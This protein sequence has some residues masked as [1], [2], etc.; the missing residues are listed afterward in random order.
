MRTI[1]AVF[2]AMSLAGGGR[3]AEVVLREQAMLEGSIVRLG[4][5]ADLSAADPG[6]VEELAAVPLLPAPTAAT[7]LYL[8]AAQ[9]RDL[10][11]ASGVDVTSLE[12]Q[13]ADSVAIRLGTAQQ[14]V[15]SP[16]GEQ[17][18]S[19]R[20]TAAGRVASAIVR[21]LHEQT[22]HEL[23]AVEVDA[24]PAITEL[25]WNAGLK[26]SVAGGK[27]PFTGRQSFQ[28]SD[29]T[30]ARTARAYAKVQR[31]EMVV[32]ATR[33]IA[34]GDFVRAP[35]VTL[36]P[37]AGVVSAQAVRSVE[38][39]VGQEAVQNIRPGAMLVETQ[40]RPPLLVQRGERV[41]VHARAAGIVVRTFAVAQQNG[42]LGDLVQVQSLEGKDRYAARVAGLRELEVFAAGSSADEIAAAA[43]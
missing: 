9:I 41:V 29:A 2:I 32:F 21:Y 26:L 11:A 43:E 40:V 15:N 31:L 6:L 17:D 39:V 20:E 18:G 14:P 27:E 33:A 38:S 4:D 3:A 35:D 25:Y 34:A 42:A 8:S 23:W 10:L 16:Q 5:V 36:R 19:P 37:Y 24:D 22:G 1:L 30:G 28:L 7:P 13:G 12:F